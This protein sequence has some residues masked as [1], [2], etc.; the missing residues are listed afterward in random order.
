MPAKSRSK[1]PLKKA[2][3]IVL[4]LI[5]TLLISAILYLSSHVGQFE[6]WLIAEVESSTGRKFT[7]EDIQ[8]EISFSPAVTLK[9]VSLENA[10]W[11][12]HPQMLKASSLTLKANLFPLL[13]GVVEI[14]Q[15]LFDNPELVI[16]TDSKGR[17]NWDFEPDSTAQK[18][19]SE[20]DDETGLV[21]EFQI[22]RVEI[23]NGKFFYRNG[24]TGKTDN[25]LIAEFSGHAI[26][27]DG[28]FQ[29]ELQATDE[30]TPF[31]SHGTMD[32]AH[33]FFQNKP[34]QY[35]LTVE[36]AGGQLHGKGSV[37]RPMDFSGWNLDLTVK[38]AKASSL[39]WLVGSDLPDFGPL[40]ASAQIK[41]LKSGYQLD[42][43]KA[44][45]GASDISGA[46]TFDTGKK[47]LKIVSQLTA[48]QIVTPGITS[49]KAVGGAQ[50]S[51]TVT[52]E[53][54][55]TEEQSVHVFSPE[56]LPFSALQKFDA[57]ISLHADKINLTG[58]PLQNLKIK[59]LLE[60]GLLTIKDASIEVGGGKMT[61]DL[62]VNSHPAP[63]TVTT[64]IHASQID[65]GAWL[66]AVR[67]EDVLTG[68]KMDGDIELSGQGSS[69]KELAAGLNGQVSW[70]AG[71]GLL[72]YDAG[73]ADENLVF[74]IAHKLK[75]LAKEEDDIKLNCWT[76][77][78]DIKDGIATSD[79]GYAF[80]S[81]KLKMLG[82]GSVDLKTEK[83]QLHISSNSTVAG[84]IAVG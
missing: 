83:V 52:P 54:S 39:S 81:D 53:E 65:L 34:Y 61:A 3:A 64:R 66:R 75:P 43:F 22:R 5:L 15:L 74:A 79:R 24:I 23:S 42:R 40:E 70:S 28:T 2:L 55:D 32:A 71:E 45:S 20:Q 68:S 10:G 51:A 31:K 11:S 14:E 29:F 62:V 50:K 84:L 26:A 30:K 69:I 18:K 27:A 12:D 63:P 72:R 56:P 13:T 33:I 19:N 77:H 6:Q 80:D 37:E 35:D 4:V 44:R 82:T 73:L 46:I 59:L 7:A 67:N 21:R 58:N 8:F 60:D 9:G 38:T 48:T 36:Y 25:F 76:V 16:E 1:K 49:D 78:Y 41:E 47:R 17:S 57:D